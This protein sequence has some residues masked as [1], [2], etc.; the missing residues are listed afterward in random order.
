MVRAEE[1]LAPQR[2]AGG[3][4]LAVGDGLGGYEVRRRGEVE[5]VEPLGGRGVVVSVL[6]RVLGSGCGWKGTGGRLV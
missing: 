2:V 4:W 3:V 5:D 6:L 1:A